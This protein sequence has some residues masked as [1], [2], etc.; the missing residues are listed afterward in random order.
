MA[1]LKQ[2]CHA[3]KGRNFCLRG[4]ILG[5][6]EWFLVAAFYECVQY[7]V[8][9]GEIVVDAPLSNSCLLCNFTDRD[10]LYFLI[11]EKLL[12]CVQYQVVFFFI[13]FVSGMDDATFLSMMM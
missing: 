3:H 12:E 5:S 8:F 11:F 9:G 13:F 7:G 1:C 10:T 4:K 2:H 6:E